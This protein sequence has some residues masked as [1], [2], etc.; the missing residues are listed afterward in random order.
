VELFVEKAR[1]NCGGGS[2]GGFATG[3]ADDAKHG[4]FR[5]CGAGYKN[6]VGRRIQIGGS[7]LDA[8]V[9]NGEKVIGDDAFD[10]LPV[11]V[12]QANPQ[13]VEF[14]A[15]E[16]GLALRFKVIGE[17]SNEINRADLGERNLLVLAIWGEQI[18]RVGLAEARGI[19]ISADRLLVGKDKDHFLVSRGWGSVFQRNQFAKTGMAEICE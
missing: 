5:E 4:Q 17:V 7:N 11:A 2:G 14:G 10:G 6:A 15:A 12:T 8:V 13:S 1:L 16:E 19:Q 3:D 9:E 18:D